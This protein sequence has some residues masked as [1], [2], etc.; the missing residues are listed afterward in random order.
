MTISAAQTHEHVDVVVIGGGSAGYAAAIRAANLGKSVV[1]A[2]KAKVGGTCLHNGCVPTK[3]LL[4]VAERADDVRD[5]AG[6]GVLAQSTGIDLDRVH[7]FRDGIVEKK[8]KGLQSLLKA[9]KVRVVE[10]TGVLESTAPLTVRIGDTR[11][12]ASDVVLAPGAQARKLA[13]VPYGEHVL[14]SDEALELTHIPECAIVIGGGVIGLEFASLWRSLGSEVTV[15]E[16]LATIAAAE[17]PNIAKTLTRALTK[18]GI[19]IKAGTGFSEITTRKSAKSPVRVTLDSGEALE[20]DTVLVAVGRVPATSDLGLEAAGV[21]LDGAAIVVGD[22]LQT[23][24]PHVWAVG[25]AV[26]GLQLA[27]RGYAHGMAVAERI[28][29]LTAPV[30]NDEQIPKVTYTHPEVASV[31]L[32]EPAAIERLGADA[33][34]TYTYNLAGN[35]KSEIL[36]TSGFVKIVREKDGPIVGVHLIGDRVGELITE[37][38]LAVAWEATPEDFNPLIHAHPTQSEALGEAFLALTGRGI[39]TL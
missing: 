24:V 20:A 23:S 7:G 15:V 1:L 17:D 4:H 26:G 36:E 10:G 31:G 16:P 37:G 22:D 6:I 18:R 14:T 21:Q 25:D 13:D 11:F 3:A 33:V 30:V 34:Q 28:A 29:G 27:H 39:H 32:S 2:E 19:V 38:Q 35:A 9:K 12:T 5:A 8:Y